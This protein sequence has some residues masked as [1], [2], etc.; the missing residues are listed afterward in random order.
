MR[1]DSRSAFWLFFLFMNLLVL[2]NQSWQVQ[3]KVYWQLL[4][5]EMNELVEYLNW[6]ETHFS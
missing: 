1:N 5:L 2:E 4:I 3:N 6:Y